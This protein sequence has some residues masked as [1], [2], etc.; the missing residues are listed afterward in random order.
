MDIKRKIR[1]PQPNIP[2]D[3][4]AKLQTI[5]KGYELR[6]VYGP[7]NKIRYIEDVID[8]TTIDDVIEVMM[9]DDNQIAWLL[10]EF[11][12][13]D[14]ARFD[15]NSFSARISI[16]ERYGFSSPGRAV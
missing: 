9:V 1:P 6:F 3:I 15:N 13:F 16:N 14:I 10:D 12:R 5:A 2:Q 7:E 4:L 11:D 8:I